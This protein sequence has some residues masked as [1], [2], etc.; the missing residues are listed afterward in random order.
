MEEQE[1]EKTCDDDEVTVCQIC[2]GT[3][4]EWFDFGEEVKE[5]SKRLYSHEDIDGD[6]PDRSRWECRP[7]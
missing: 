1:E 4:C 7:K 6:C 3:P 2:G 5:Y